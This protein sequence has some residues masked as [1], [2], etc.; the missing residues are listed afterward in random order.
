MMCTVLKLSKK[1]LNIKN[2]YSGCQQDSGND[3]G[4]A[5]DA[6]VTNVADLLGPSHPLSSCVHGAS[7]KIYT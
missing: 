4:T 5:G 7:G 1:K 6:Q 2:I 3:A